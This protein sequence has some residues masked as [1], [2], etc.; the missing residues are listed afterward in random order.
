MNNELLARVWRDDVPH[1]VIVW[2]MVWKHYP[3]ENWFLLAV[4]CEESYK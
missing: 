3:K 2:P 1:I 4:I